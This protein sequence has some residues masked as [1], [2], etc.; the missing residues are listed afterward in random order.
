MPSADSGLERRAENPTERGF[1]QAGPCRNRVTDGTSER[2]EDD[3]REQGFANALC[4]PLFLS[5]SAVAAT[6]RDGKY[7]ERDVQFSKAHFSSTKCC[8]LIIHHPSLQRSR[9]PKLKNTPHL[10]SR[11]HQ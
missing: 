11:S 7:T 3:H 10:L 9:P 6:L 8:H 1:H 4:L 5:P 2:E